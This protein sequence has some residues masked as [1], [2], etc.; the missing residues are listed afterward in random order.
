MALRQTN[1]IIETFSRTISDSNLYRKTEKNLEYVHNDLAVFIKGLKRLVIRKGKMMTAFDDINTLF[2]N[3][4]YQGIYTMI[5]RLYKEYLVT[6]FHGQR[7]TK[8][9]ELIAYCNFLVLFEDYEMNRQILPEEGERVIRKLNM[10]HELGES[11]YIRV[12]VLSKI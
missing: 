8:Y 12:K 9:K 6:P 7:Y 10:G 3:N 2:D 11:I 4:N 1:E 5:N